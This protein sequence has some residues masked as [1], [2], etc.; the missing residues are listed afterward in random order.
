LKFVHRAKAAVSKCDPRYAL[1]WLRQRY[2][3]DASLWVERHRRTTLPLGAIILAIYKEREAVWMPAEDVKYGFRAA[4]PTFVEREPKRPRIDSE[5]KSGNGTKGGGKKKTE[6]P[7]TDKQ[8]Q[9]NQGAASSGDKTVATTKNGVKLCADWN[10]GKNC[11]DPCKNGE[12]HACNRLLN[13]GM[14]CSLPSHKSIDCW[15]KRR[16]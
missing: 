5:G 12:R 1:D 15:A 11:P 6:K 14:A 13:G 2:T 16:A 3:Q 9:Q 8:W 10:M 4:Q 7:K